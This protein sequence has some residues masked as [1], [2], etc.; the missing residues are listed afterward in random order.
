MQPTRRPLLFGLLLSLLLPAAQAATPSPPLSIDEAYVQE[1]VKRATELKLAR[2]RIWQV[3]LHYREGTFGGWKSEIDDPIFFNSSR[4]HKDPEAELEGTLRAFYAPVP[5]DPD[6]QQPQCL[7]VDRY[8][9]LKKELGFDPKR[10]PE[11]SCPMF[12]NWAQTHNPGSVTLIFASYYMGNAASMFGH[13]LLRLNNRKH[14]GAGERLLDY[15]VNYAANPTTNNALAYGVLGIVG[16]FRGDFS[17]VPYYLK[18]EE[19]SNME[20]RDLWEY[21]LNFNESEIDAMVAHLWAVGHTRPRYYFFDR[22]CSYMI[23]GLMESARPSLRLSEKFGAWTIPADTVR[24]VLAQEGLIREVN[25]RPSI[26]TRLME[27]RKQ[28]SAEEERLYLQIVNVPDERSQALAAA[29]LLPKE[30]AARVMDLSLDFYRYKKLAAKKHVLDPEDEPFAKELLLTRANLGAKSPDKEMVRPGDPNRRPDA[31]HP[32]ERVVVKGGYLQGAGGSFVSV[33]YRPAFH[34]LNAIPE[35]YPPFSQVEFLA[36]DLRVY[37]TGSATGV[38]VALERL[39]L[40]KMVT[41][42]PWD[43][44]FRKS[45]V[46]FELGWRAERDPAIGDGVP[47]SL[48]G[49]KGYSFATEG[50]RFD[51]FVMPGAEGQLSSSLPAGYRLGAGGDVGLVW[52]MTEGFGLQLGA[53]AIYA[54]LGSSG[55]YTK[56]MGELR[57]A[58]SPRWDMRVGANAWASAQE[59]L[60]T[61]NVY[62]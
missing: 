12:K 10:L 20:S 32:T 18:V 53:H 42:T 40:F 35:G 51:F 7:F 27:A 46:N 31:G 61:L 33:G 34:D 6:A 30:S 60:F 44:L 41:A 9:Y 15:G 17:N 26:A 50:G 37:P 39:T 45:S 3:L 29:K 19:Y 59:A 23:L 54:F 57:Y 24:V 43:P 58:P 8:R 16:G 47:F 14:E 4:G 38:K 5:A 2:S 22:N 52:R 48:G 49:G 21:E 36:T 55:L 56:F 28:L 62:Y 1:L 25:F 13:T 11:V